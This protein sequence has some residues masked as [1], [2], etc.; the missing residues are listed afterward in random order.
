MAKFF[1]DRPIFAWV[2]AIV[3]MLVG[4]ASIFTLPISQ[5]PTIAPPAVQITANYPG[6]SAKTV[7]DT[8][9]QVIE[10][11]MSGLDNFL[12]MSSTSDDS[13][14]ATITISFAPGTNPDI[15]QVQVQNKL[16]LATPI[17]PQVVQQLGLKVTKSSSSYLLWIA[18]NSEDGSMGRNDLTNYVASHVLDPISR[19]NGVGQTL[20]LGS[21]YAMRIWLDPNK[22]N[23]FSLTPADVSNAISAQNVQI[24]GGQIGGTPAKAGTVLQATITEQTLLQTPEQFGNILLKVNQDGSQV[25]LKDVAQIGLGAENYNFDTKYMGQPTAGL[26]IQLAT[27]ANALATADAIKAKVKELSKYFPHGMVVHYPYDTTPFVRLSI[28]EVVKT[29]LEGIVL[30]FLVMY[31][32]LQNLRATL[33]PT[34]AVPVVLLGTFAIMGLAGFTIN[35]LSMF[36]LVLAI[37]LLVDDAIVVVENV[38]RVMVEEGLPPK[39]ATKKAMGQ[40]TSALVGVALVLSAVFVPVAFSGGSVGAIYRQFSLTIV[41]AMVLSVLVALILTPALCATILKP[42]EKGH[43]EEKKGFFGWFNRNFDKSREKY[44]VGVHHVIKRSGR[45]LVIYLAVIVGVGFLFVRLPKSFLPDEDQGY[46]FM[47]VQ[48]PSGSTQETT[49]R[50][51]A[52]ITDYMAKEEKNVVDSVFTVNGFSFAGRGQN[53]G[54]VFVKLR[55]FEERRAADRKVQALIK[56]TFGHYAGYKDGIVIPFNPPSIPELGTAAGFD[57]ELTDNGGLGHDALMAAR[58]QLLGM[59]AKDPTLAL[60]RPNGLNDTPQYKV[61]IDREKANALGVTAAAIDQTF[62]IAWA[63]QYVN[64]FLDTD[65]R[66]KKVYVQADSPFRVTPEDLGIWYVRNSAGGMVPFSAFATGHWTYGSPKLER[67]NGISAVEI[68]GQASTG[69]STGQ[70]MAAMQRLAAQLPTGIGYSWTGLSFQ[71]IQ[72]GSQAPI[73]YAISILV[74]F[75]CLAALYES[76]SIPFSVIMVVP[77]GVIGALLAS[78]LRGLENDVFFQVGLLTTVG[79]SAKNA[80]LIVEFARELQV[81]EKMGPVEAALEAARLR[82]RPILMTSLAFILGVLPLAISNGAGSASQHAIGTGVIG[83]MLTATF[84]AI[85]MI[86]M[87]FVKVRAIFGGEKEDA[88]EALRLAQEHA[89]RTDGDGNQGH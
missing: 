6:A 38:E 76:W 54:L 3:L 57:F 17:L 65:G 14:N 42:I 74:V 34:I 40:I 13:G 85:F 35:T 59:A 30:V 83:G 7:E 39:E 25:R 32:F 84:L 22:L 82:L 89:H 36:G 43:P 75:L 24:A 50:T 19:L 61:D 73:L 69:N 28:E 49:A 80:I 58:N 60:V 1:I 15:A 64:N 70:A 4:V 77:L 41:S 56:R 26:G 48:T 79:L 67:Y 10:Q 86:P 20:L 2:I 23:N 21:Q 68:Q 53:A 44:H 52:D 37:G 12:Y 33:I 66:I 9:T 18:F 81:G 5:Y 11:Q 27:G 78:T 88:D 31:L 29:L 71:E 63:S 72:S 16:S 51:L 87:F 55:P 47:I 46:M 8:V 45:W 62:S